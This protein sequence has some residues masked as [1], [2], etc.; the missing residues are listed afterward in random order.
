[1][2]KTLIKIRTFAQNHGCMKF[3]L[4]KKGLVFPPLYPEAERILATSKSKSRT[5]VDGYELRPNQIDLIPQPGL[6][7]QLCQSEANLVFICG[8]ATSGKAQP[9]T[10]K[11]LTPNG[12]VEMGSLN[13]GDAILAPDNSTQRVLNIFEQGEI[14]VWRLTF[15]DGAQTECCKN[16]LWKVQYKSA[17]NNYSD[18]KVE[19]LEDVL[20]KFKAG[21]KVAIPFCSEIDFAAKALPIDPYILGILLGD[22]HFRKYQTFLSNPEDEIIAAVRAAGYKA[23]KLSG[24]NCDYR[25]S[26]Q[27]L[28]RHIRELGLAHKLSN[29]KFIPEIYKYSDIVSR[30]AL[31]QGLIDTDGTVDKNGHIFYYTVSHQLATDVQW[32]VR[33]LGGRCH[34]TLKRPHYVY[35]GERKEGQLCYVLSINTEHNTDLC[36]LTSKRSRTFDGFR[37]GKGTLRHTLKE[38]EYVGKKQ[39]RCIMVSGAEHLYVTDDFIVT[40]NTFAMYL[41]ALQ[42]VTHYGFAAKLISVRLQDSKKG[43]SMFRDG[44][45]VCGNFANCEYNSADYPTFSW[46]QWNSS[47]QLIHSN[48]NVNNPAEWEQFQ[49]YAKK[50]Q[51]SLIMVDEATEMKE[52]KMFAYW[53][54]RNRDSSGMTPQMVLSFNPSH[55]H[56]TTQMLCDAGY[57]GADWYLRKDMIGKVRYWYNKGKSPAEIVWGDSREEV[58]DAA[59][60][61]D[62]PDDLAA[63]IS[64]LDYVKSFTVLTG[65]A[66]SNRELVNATGGQSVANL[67]ATGAEQRQIVGEG[68]FGEVETEEINVSRE[69][70]NNLWLNPVSDDVNMYATM[71]ISS[72]KADNDKSPMVI[73]RGLQI[74]GVELFSGEPNEIAGWI[75]TKLNAYGVDV[76]RFAYDATGHGYWMQGLTNGVAVTANKRAIQEVDEFGNAVT[77]DDYFNCRSQLLGRTEVM[78]KRGDIACSLSPDLRIPYAKGGATRTIRDILYDEINVFATT[79]RNKRIYYRSKD[80]YRAKFR[81]SPDLMDAI[82]LRAVFELDARPKKA[83][84]PTASPFVYN[85][86]Y[87]AFAYAAKNRWNKNL[88]R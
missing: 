46:P 77:R 69:M 65:T 44:V 40:H 78:I 37:R 74:V 29:E 49:D 34:I 73:W 88:L 32:I 27:G 2:S 82:C 79:T 15:D 26:G 6:Q 17:H 57:I 87:S 58:A 36:R 10:S 11:V 72:G 64:R 83:P 39:C 7:E 21:R 23:A 43:G 75:K 55:D 52:F 67:H 76:T 1:M 4:A 13:I 59:G 61:I 28:V 24:D 81:H 45:T 30:R 54:S 41:N 19:R 3:T 33:S 68:Y 60:L 20:A 71:D 84:L 14:D 63:G 50:V 70:I 35:N 42:G 48:F 85:N 16:H 5:L 12:F 86:L 47:L 18:W 8:Q 80:E 53:F 56:W 9:Y 31:L 51:A 62:R 25:V 66:A 22:G 38:C